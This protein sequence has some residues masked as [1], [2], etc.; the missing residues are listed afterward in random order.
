MSS[1]L[2]S[3]SIAGFVI[4][5]LAFTG[6][7]LTNSIISRSPVVIGIQ[8]AAGLLMLWARVTFGERSFHAAADPTEGGLVTT[9]P[10]R[11]IRHPIYTSICLFTWAGVAA[12]LSPLSATLALV[13][14]G[15]ALLRI[16]CEEPLVAERYPEYAE[17]ARRTKRM[18]P[19][20]F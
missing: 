13:F 8:V 14:T 17:Y 12:H 16:F 19:F 2:K 15:G 11:F 9:G 7:F 10:Y 18:I 6:L 5:L 20:L 1:M 4:L 3:L